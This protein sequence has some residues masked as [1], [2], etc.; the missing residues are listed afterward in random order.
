[1]SVAIKIKMK[2]NELNERVSAARKETESR[3]ETFYPGPGCV[4][5]YCYPTIPVCE[6]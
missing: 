3:G 1:M 2:P 4:L 5:D 6:L